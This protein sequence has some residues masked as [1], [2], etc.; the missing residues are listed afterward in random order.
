MLAESLQRS[1]GGGGGASLTQPRRMPS[2]WA[3]PASSASANATATGA[4]GILT[5]M[6][7]SLAIRCLANLAKLPAEATKNGPSAPRG[8]DHVPCRQQPCRRWAFLARAC[9]FIGL[10]CHRPCRA[11][12][13]AG[14]QLRGARGPFCPAPGVGLRRAWLSRR[15]TALEEVVPDQA[16]AT[17]LIT[18]AAQRIGRVLARDFAEQGW[19]VAIHCRASRRQADELAQD[20]ARIGTPSAVLTADLAVAEEVEALLP[21]CK[22][23]LGAPSC[24]INNAATF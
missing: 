12:G 22:R 24:L 5:F 19:R 13:H 2:A 18:G 23:V 11:L 21:E 6:V 9:L 10:G 1:C 7:A 8:E 3:D 4:A 17:V 15:Q 16:A 20:L 14:A